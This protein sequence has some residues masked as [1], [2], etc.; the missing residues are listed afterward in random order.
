VADDRF[1]RARR[2][3]RCE[4]QRGRADGENAIASSIANERGSSP[5]RNWI[6]AT[7]LSV[8]GRVGDEVW[9]SVGRYGGDD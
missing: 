8:R 9:V 3:R 6:Q 5:C 2:R 7:T 1:A 4:G